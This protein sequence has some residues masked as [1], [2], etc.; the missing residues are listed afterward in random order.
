M[1]V[2]SFIKKHGIE[3]GCNEVSLHRYGEVE[4]FFFNSEEKRN[5]STTFDIKYPLTNGGHSELDALFRDF[6]K[7]NGCANN[8]VTGVVLNYVA[9]T[10]EE[11]TAI[12]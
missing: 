11:L 12:C 1:T 5:D 7:E 3:I 6:C 2:K 8:Q 9:P 4:V 10:Y